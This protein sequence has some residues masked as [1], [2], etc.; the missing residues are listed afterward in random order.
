MTAFVV[1][2]AIVG[3]IGVLV[4]LVVGNAA[5]DGFVAGVMTAVL[6]LV[7]AFGYHG[8]GGLLDWLNRRRR[9]H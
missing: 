2:M 7:L 1:F 9:T 5:L 3:G 6:L 8:F 4:A